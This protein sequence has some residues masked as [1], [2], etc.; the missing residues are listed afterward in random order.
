MSLWGTMDEVEHETFLRGTV[1]VEKCSERTK[2]ET[3]FFGETRDSDGN[4]WN[5]NGDGTWSQSLF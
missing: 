2:L 5:D 1:T 4:R 3:D